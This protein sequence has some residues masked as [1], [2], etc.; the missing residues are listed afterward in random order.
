MIQLLT[1]LPSRSWK[2]DNLDM[3]FCARLETYIPD[4][5]ILVLS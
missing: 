1:S 4:S 3:N 5:S 2:V